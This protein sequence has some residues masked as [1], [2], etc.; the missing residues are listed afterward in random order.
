MKKP[1]NHPAHKGPLAGLQASGPGMP[2][3]S[4]NATKSPP[5]P[6][7]PTLGLRDALKLKQIMALAQAAAMEGGS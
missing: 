5:A 3:P 4:G 2:S 7:D 6:I 1:H